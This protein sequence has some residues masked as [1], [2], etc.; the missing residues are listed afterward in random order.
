MEQSFKKDVLRELREG[1][2]RILLHDEMEERP[3][4]FSIIPL[5]ETVSEEDILT[6]RDIFN[7]MAKEG[8]KASH[9]LPLLK[10]TDIDFPR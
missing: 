2:G 9:L 10:P 3:G 7:L 1:N 8:Y 6:P 4:I 5:W